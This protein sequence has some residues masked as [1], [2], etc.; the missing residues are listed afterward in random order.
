LFV[1]Q[2]PVRLDD[3]TIEKIAQRVVA[4]IAATGL[5]SQCRPLLTAAEVAA[6]WGVERS[7]I[8]EHARDLGA[9]R[10]GTGPAPRLRFDPAKLQEFLDKSV[11]RRVA[12]RDTSA[13]RPL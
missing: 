4:M 11:I 10:L 3:H 5:V 8:Y 9:I 13:S 7:W 2:G 1:R 6:S 12:R